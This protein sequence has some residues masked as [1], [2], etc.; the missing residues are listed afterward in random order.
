M[1]QKIWLNLSSK[2]GCIIQSL[3]MGS[4]GQSRG[5]L[6]K[7]LPILICFFCFFKC[8]MSKPPLFCPICCCSPLA[9][10]MALWHSKSKDWMKEEAANYM[11]DFMTPVDLLWAARHR[12]FIGITCWPRRSSKIPQGRAIGRGLSYA[13]TCMLHIDDA[14][15]YVKER[16]LWP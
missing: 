14:V 8:S 3:H 16:S 9:S 1:G 6:W 13:N 2:A 4:E 12:W 11:K 15:A 10:T 7:A 5:K